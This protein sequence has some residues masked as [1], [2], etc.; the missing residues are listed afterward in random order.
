MAITA[1][2]AAMINPMGL[3]VSTAFS[4]VCAAVSALVTVPHA[5]CAS[6]AM[7]VCPVKSATMTSPSFRVPF[8]AAWAM[9]AFFV[10]MVKSL[11]CTCAFPNAVAMP[12]MAVPTL[13]AP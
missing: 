9:F 5:A 8:I 4:A 11:S 3:A 10:D 1:A 12:W 2:M 7:V 6:W 13:K